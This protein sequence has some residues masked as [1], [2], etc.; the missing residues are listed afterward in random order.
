MWPGIGTVAVPPH[1]VVGRTN[2][3]IAVVVAN[4]RATTKFED[5]IAARNI[6]TK[7]SDITA[8]CQLIAGQSTQASC[9][10]ENRKRLLGVGRDVLFSSAT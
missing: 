3:T 7:S 8:E 4:E 5:D 10:A 9:R 6:H 2:N 1:N